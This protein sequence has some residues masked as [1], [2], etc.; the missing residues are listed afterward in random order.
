ML[1]WNSAVLTNS[2]S[3]LIEYGKVSVDHVSCITH[4]PNTTDIHLLEHFHSV[5]CTFYYNSNF[6]ELFVSLFFF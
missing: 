3:G 4:I 5:L 2:N 6:L 1:N